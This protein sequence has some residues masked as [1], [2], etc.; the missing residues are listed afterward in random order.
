MRWSKYWSFNFG[1]G[2]SA[3]KIGNYNRG[4]KNRK[5][6]KKK[7]KGIYRTSQSIGKINVFLE[8]VLSESFPS[9][10]VTVHFTSLGCL[11]VLCRSLDLLWGQLDSNLVLLLCV[12]ASNVHNYQN[13]CIFFFVFL[14]V[15]FGRSSQ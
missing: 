6:K 14:F 13:D 1:I 5:R 9:L 12:L 3:N 7:S 4:W 8:S 15:S 2:P 11:P 10:G